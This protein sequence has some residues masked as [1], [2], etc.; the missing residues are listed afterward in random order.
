MAIKFLNDIS[1]D[2]DVTVDGFLYVN[3]S[4]QIISGARFNLSGD[5]AISGNLGIGVTSSNNERL[6]VRGS[7]A[8]VQIVNSSFSG[9]TSVVFGG[10]MNFT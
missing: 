6:H 3:T 4:S 8:A 9:Q 5:A 2:P 7:S 1:V 10:A